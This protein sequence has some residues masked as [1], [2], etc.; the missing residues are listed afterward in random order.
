MRCLVRLALITSIVANINCGSATSPTGSSGSSGS[1]SNLQGTMSATIAN[2]PW[3]A[4]GSVTATYAP[5]QN[6]LAVSVL[7]LVG[8]DS[9]LTQTLVFAVGS[10]AVGTALTPGTYQVG[11]TTGTNAL[12]TVTT[13]AITTYQ[14]S[15]P[16]GI[17]TVTITSFSTATRRASGT[18][19]FVVIQTGA[20]AQKAIAGGAFDVTF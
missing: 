9:P 19:N 17:G 3:T 2:I 8:Q 5:A 18:F 4:N 14:A 11:T 15:G 20:S 16:V 1:G 13:G 6:N 7:N 12:L 10:P